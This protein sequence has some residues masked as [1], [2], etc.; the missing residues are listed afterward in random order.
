[1]EKAGC[2]KR[3]ASTPLSE[4]WTEIDGLRIHYS[5]A[6]TGRP[7]LLIHG[8]LGGS[9]CWRFNLPVLARQYAIYAVDLPGAGLS[10]APSHTDCSMEAQAGRLLQFIRKME[11]SEL[12]VIGSSWGGAI[13]LLLAAM[14]V[15]AVEAVAAAEIPETEL[16]S[17]PSRP[18]C[19]KI[20]SLVLCAPVN[21]WSALGQKRIKFLKSYAG[22]WFLRMVWP[23]SRSIQAIALNRLYGDPARISPGSLEGYVSM[24]LR[25]ARARNILSV[26]RSWRQDVGL[27]QD[28]ISRVRIP[29]LLA[30]G[31]K[32]GAVDIR[33]ADKLRQ[34]LPHCEL[35]LFPGAGHLP[36]EEVPG[37]FNARI[38]EFLG[39]RSNEQIAIGN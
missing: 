14:D 16:P 36:F 30:W 3:E 8:L 5:Q 1:M 28:R 25:P 27:L 32:D 17:R 13:A 22:G 12:S 26:L 23:L 33:S 6:G 20:R 18:S 31:T 37:E 39:E 24:I 19:K 38:L 9:F 11:L 10:D 7:L 21:P 4:H 34:V 29:T 2:P 35:A 15:E